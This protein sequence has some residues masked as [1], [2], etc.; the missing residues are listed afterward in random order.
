MLTMFFGLNGT[1]IKKVIRASDEPKLYKI[2]PSMSLLTFVKSKDT[3]H[4]APSKS[5]QM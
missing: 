2:Y 4:F 5:P 3:P 1:I